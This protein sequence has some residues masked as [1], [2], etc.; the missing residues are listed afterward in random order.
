MSNEAVN[1][2]FILALAVNIQSSV[3]YQNISP[4]RSLQAQDCLNLLLWNEYWE[5]RE[6]RSPV[7][8]PPLLRPTYSQRMSDGIH[9]LAIKFI[10]FHVISFIIHQR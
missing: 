9:V 6:T 5:E 2:L 1:I 10:F 8:W 4:P 7:A 3:F